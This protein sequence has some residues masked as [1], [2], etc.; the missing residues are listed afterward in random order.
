MPRPRKGG[1]WS[2][3]PRPTL[4]I[5]QLHFY[6]FYFYRKLFFFFLNINS[7]HNSFVLNVLPI[8]RIFI[9]SPS[10]AGNEKEK[11]SFSFS[12]SFFSFFVSFF[13]IRFVLFFSVPFLFFLVISLII[14]FFFFSYFSALSSC[15]I[16]CFFFFPVS[17]IVWYLISSPV[18]CKVLVRHHE[19]WQQ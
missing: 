14:F 9:F 1:A 5:R 10:R 13:R 18:A 15:T 19:S 11:K 7:S 4:G 16:T 17:L 8:C 3:S 2:T 6:L 12:Y